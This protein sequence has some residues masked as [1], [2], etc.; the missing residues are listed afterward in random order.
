M[1][2][3]MKIRAVGTGLFRTE[4]QTYI[5]YRET[6]MTKLNVALRNF[7]NAARNQIHKMTYV[8]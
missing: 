5:N 3:L 6:D 2:N 4:G 7:A 1:S 8:H